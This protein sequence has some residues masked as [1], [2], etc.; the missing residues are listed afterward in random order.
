M[1]DEHFADGVEAVPT[2]PLYQGGAGPDRDAIVTR[3]SGLKP[4]DE[5]GARA[6]VADVVRAGF[7]D[8]AVE[9][10]LKPLAEALGVNIPAAKKFWKDAARAARETAAAEA[11]RR[12]AERR[13]DGERKSVEQRQRE[14][15][16]EHDRLW[17][18]CR[19]IAESPTLLADMENLA[20]R[21]GLVGERASLRG[22][23]LTASSRLN[24]KSAICLLR[25]GAPAGG[26]NFLFDK[27]FALIPD[28]CVVRMSS[29][30]PLSLVY[31]GG[32][33]ED[34]LRHKIV[35]V[36]EAAIIADKNRVESPL[37][38]MLRILISEGRLDHNVALPQASGPPE[39]VHI[40]RNGPVAVIITS[41]RDNVE[42]ELLTRLMTSDADETG[43]QTQAVLAGR[44]SER[45]ETC[46]RRGD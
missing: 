3:I 6:I 45:R 1:A 37:T 5:D 18:S 43:R 15:S 30:S 12:A 32:E 21:L 34:A 16:E 22:S 4:L 8:L 41:A 27:T 28:D 13:A 31:Y 19:K 14:T 44:P 26:K 7:S 36:P 2:I 23:Y 29:G 24:K 25:R 10:L 33:D 11:I 42:D 40:K 17:S 38:I 46:R 35:Y 9:T 39:T 20:L